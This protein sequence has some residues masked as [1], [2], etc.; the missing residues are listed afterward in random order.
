M[1]SELLCR[2]PLTS[3]I[4]TY[5]WL[6]T[7]KVALF[8]FKFPVFFPDVDS[9]QSISSALEEVRSTVGDKGLNC[10]INNAGI[11]ISLDINTVTPV[12]MIKT[13]QVNTVAPLFS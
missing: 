7:T 9:Q 4:F 2:L 6:S 8:I 3:T 12:A 5:A 10:L 13:F 1:N 11:E